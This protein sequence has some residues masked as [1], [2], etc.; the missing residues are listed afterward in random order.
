MNNQQADAL[1]MTILKRKHSAHILHLVNE[2]LQAEELRQKRLD[3]TKK[4]ST[5]KQLEKN[6]NQERKVE[7][8]RIERLQSEQRM[9]VAAKVKQIKSERSVAADP[10][11]PGFGS[12]SDRIPNIK[13]GNL[14][15]RTSKLRGHG[16]SVVDQ[17]SGRL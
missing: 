12:T 5:R 8:Q 13:P 10:S 14:R 3:L 4:S 17:R 11:A 2:N 15:K 16:A 9:I 6:F 7:R 1:D